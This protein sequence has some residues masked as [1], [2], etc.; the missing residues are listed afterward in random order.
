MNIAVIS[1]H[2]NHTG[3]TTIAS[4]LGLE[5]SSRGGKVCI[6]H[7]LPKSESLYK[8][9]GITSVEDK[10]VSPARLVKM[11]KSGALKPDE[12][13]DYCKSINNK[14]EL[15]SANDENFTQED[16]ILALE[17]ITQ[18]FPHDY[19]IYDID[20]DELDSPA[21]RLI[22]NNCDV[23]II[24]I[25][26]NVIE[27]GKF[28]ERK[29]KIL[30]SLGKIP[31]LVVINRFCDVQGSVKETAQMMGVKA[32]KNWSVIRYNPWITYGTNFGKMSYIYGKMVAS[33]Y[34]VADVA[35]DV[36]ALTSLILK[37]KVAKRQLNKEMMQRKLESRK[38]TG[39]GGDNA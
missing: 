34:R 29:S 22:L 15:F 19:I 10:T 36:K 3:T 7:S 32:P 11:I 16:M 37:V 5:L 35:S 4:L 18:S 9:F 30:N 26:Q 13:S 27:L 31:Q 1:P 6:T 33:D 20:N 17:C 14:L 24:V 39:D 8:Y 23:A 25:N 2:Y 21:N 12:V 38:A 28:K